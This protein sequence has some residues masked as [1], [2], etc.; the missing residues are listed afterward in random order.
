M[1]CIEEAIFKAIKYRKFN[2][3]ITETFDLACVQA[4]EALKKGK[5]PFPVVVKDCYMFVIFFLTL[6]IFLS[7]IV[8]Y[9]LQRSF[10]LMLSDIV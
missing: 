6:F 8:K 7:F 5:T 3:L 1:E 2:S 4:K 9:V 10:L